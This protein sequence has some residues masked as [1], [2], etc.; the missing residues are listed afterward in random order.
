MV[1]PLVVPPLV[2]PP[3]VVPAL[4]VPAM[5]ILPLVAP[6]PASQASDKQEQSCAIGPERKEVELDLVTGWSSNMAECRLALTDRLPGAGAV[7]QHSA[8]L[9]RLPFHPRAPFRQGGAALGAHVTRVRTRRSSRC[10]VPCLRIR[11]SQGGVMPDHPSIPPD[12]RERVGQGSG[13]PPRTQS[14]RV[15]S[16]HG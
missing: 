12:V 4:V 3:L 1:P 13:R 14:T 10:G 15:V 6:Q 2:V 16:V 11:Y 7:K 9:N 8:A 5:V